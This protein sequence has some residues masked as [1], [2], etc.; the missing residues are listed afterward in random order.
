MRAATFRSRPGIAQTL[1]NL[2]GPQSKLYLKK[3]IQYGAT[4][5][6]LLWVFAEGAWEETLATVK[7]VNAIPFN[8]LTPRRS[9]PGSR[10]SAGR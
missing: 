3:G 7:I 4:V 6:D 10:P 5:N 8:K 9:P 1:V 2:P